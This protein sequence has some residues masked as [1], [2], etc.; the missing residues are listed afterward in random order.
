MD[1]NKIYTPDEVRKL[2]R[3][4]TPKNVKRREN[5]LNHRFDVYNSESSY[6][7]HCDPDIVIYLYSETYS[8]AWA[9]ISDFLT[10]FCVKNY[11][12]RHTVLP[13]EDEERT[14]FIGDN[15]END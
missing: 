7:C 13:D 3:L 1:S 11:Y 15:N 5:L 14:K 4:M 9:K 12:T 10:P 8:G 2:R 6:I